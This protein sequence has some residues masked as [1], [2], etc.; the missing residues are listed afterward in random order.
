MIYTSVLK[1]QILSFLQEAFSQADFYDGSNEFQWSADAT[2][3]KV[4]ILDAYTEDIAGVDKRPAIIVNRG[5]MR[6]MNT[7]IDQRETV[8]F[9]SGKERYK[10]LI[11]AEMTINCFSRSGLEAERLAHLVFASI[12]FFAREIRK[13]GSFEI[14]SAV[15]G[16]ESI[17][18]ADSAID[19]SVVPVAVGIYIQDNWVKTFSSSLMQHAVFTFKGN[20]NEIS[21]VTDP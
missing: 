13:R 4:L 19:L 7:S 1:D 18:Q 5:S 14:N 17:V 9:R 2:L 12:Q 3:T 21:Q 8:D 20:G 10:D 6:W 16:P 11:S 15:I